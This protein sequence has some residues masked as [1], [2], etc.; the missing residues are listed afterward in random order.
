MLFRSGFRILNILLK[1]AVKFGWVMVGFAWVLG[2][3]VWR[4]PARSAQNP[5]DQVHLA[6]PADS[7]STLTVAWHTADAAAPS[8][9]QYRPAG[10]AVWSFVTG[11]AAPAFDAGL[12]HEA[13]ITGLSPNT[14]YQYRLA[15]GL[16]GWTEIFTTTTAPDAGTTGPA[17]FN[18]V[19]VA[20][21]GLIGREDG[22]ASGTE[23]VISMIQNLSP[24]LLL[25]G[26]DYAYY[27]TDTRFSTLEEAIDAWFNQMQ[28]LASA[29][30]LMPAYGNHEFNDADDADG[31]DEWAARFPA[32]SGFEGFFSF[33][34]GNAHFI[35]VYAPVGVISDAALLWLE[36]DILAAQAAGQ[37]WVIPYFHVAP[38]SDGSNH[39]S[40]L[41]LRNKLGP[42]F[43]QHG[44]RL[45]LTSHDQSYERTYPLTDVPATN[46]PATADRTCYGPGEGV[47]WLK[48]SPGGKLSNVNWDFSQFLTF[49]PPAYTAVRTN[50]LH[51]LVELEFNN[52]G[53][54]AIKSWGVPER[55]G[56]PIAVD[57]FL[58]TGASCNPE[59][60]FDPPVVER[61]L[62]FDDPPVTAQVQLSTST[63]SLPGGIGVQ[64]DS[65]WLAAT[66]VGGGAYS[67]ELDPAGLLPGT[68]TSELTAQASGY[69]GARLPVI[70]TVRGNTGEYSL[71]VSQAPDRSTPVDLHN[72]TVSGDMYV[73]TTPDL[74]EIG[75][76]R[77]FIDHQNFRRESNAPFDL[78][79]TT[80][81]DQALPYDT[82]QL[83]DGWHN[84]TAVVV[85]ADGSSELASASFRVDNQPGPDPV[86]PT[87]VTISGPAIGE[88]AVTYTFT[89]SV[90]P[91]STTVPLTYVWSVP[92]QPEVL[93]TAGLTDTY[94]FAWDSAGSQQVTVKASNAAGFVT[95]VLPVVI[96]PPPVAVISPAEVS[97][98][99]PTSG[100]IGLSY[101]FTAT[102][103]PISTTLPLTFT[104]TAAD[105]PTV[106][107]TGG[108]TAVSAFE[109]AAPGIKLL[110]V[111]SSNPAGST[112]GSHSILVFILPEYRIALPVVIKS[113]H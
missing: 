64:S 59:L 90:I 80:T 47:I 103:S 27:N 102:V 66:P 75:Q 98:T 50:R 49:P 61:R 106:T 62:D 43:E 21:T 28:P 9:V 37:T 70:L 57:Q 29:A 48:A 19:Y 55:G 79:G 2:L 95:G 1:N 10:S 11:S 24:R 107:Q 99:G 46:T 73:F 25:G 31:Y 78:V 51:H 65:A 82:T 4:Q 91:I 100:E 39:S 87:D 69:T 20:D 77:F 88:P 38:F 105:L 17:G 8:T 53:T 52:D 113:Q 54:L 84:I 33:D 32:P 23:S 6:W 109:W 101:T 22:L 94:T 35:S 104:W 41:T 40:S 67:L 34:V 15:D 110:T 18:V 74:P 42:L 60:R 26:G 56:A 14:A 112:V 30:P 83:P 68:Y 44:I 12:F 96:N 45:V 76:V 13:T 7:A 89:A 71:Q 36:Q 16:G 93:H 63:G 5:V 108:L 86:A 92:G 81:G 97:I 85:A 58:L 3:I 111:T 72:R